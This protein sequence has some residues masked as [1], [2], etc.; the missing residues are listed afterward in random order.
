MF[1]IA[2]FFFCFASLPLGRG[3]ALL[4]PI[5]PKMFRHRL[6]PSVQHLN[7]LFNI[8]S[9]LPSPLPTLPTPPL[10]LRRATFPLR[11]IIFQPT[12]FPTLPPPPPTLPTPPASALQTRLS[13]YPNFR[14]HPQL[15]QH[16]LQP[17]FTSSPT[18]N[19]H[20]QLCL[21]HLQ[22]CFNRPQ[23]FQNVSTPHPS[24]PS[25]L[26]GVSSNTDF[27]RK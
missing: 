5:L 15:C 13:I 20:L 18:L 2:G 19:R 10:T 25:S 23:P 9:I 21:H 16:Y 17:F 8:P 7:Q 26:A 6:R 1:E 3:H 14:R 12:S 11:A 27:V 4:H 24:Q 22:P